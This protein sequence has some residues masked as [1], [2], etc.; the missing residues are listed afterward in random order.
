MKRFC[1]YAVLSVALA[2]P[3]AAEPLSRFDVSVAQSDLSEGLPD[4]REASLAYSRRFADGWSGAIRVE[5]SERFDREDVY[6]EARADRTL[7]VGA[8]Y[9]ALGGAP[10]A[11]FRAEIAL[12]GGAAIPLTPR[13][14]LLL[15]AD[16]SRFAAG[17]AFGF[18][19]GADQQIT[20]N[21]WRVRLQA[22]SVTDDGGPTLVGGAVQVQGPAAPRTSVR[23][24]YV[25]APE[26]SEGVTVRVRGW[27]GGVLF[28]VSDTWLIR[29]DLTHEDRGAYTRSELAVGAALRF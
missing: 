27:N 6:A 17:D 19:L 12:R 8:F 3:A 11:D 10:D 29:A 25:D 2:A 5:H 28:D 14:T 24:G 23:L 4:W 21:D 7:D 16:A 9:V 18:K 1:I 15:D 26:R 22:I 13:T 20:A